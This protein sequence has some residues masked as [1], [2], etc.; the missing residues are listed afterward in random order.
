ML[1]IY[2]ISPKGFGCGIIAFNGQLLTFIQH[3]AQYAKQYQLCKTEFLTSFHC[4]GTGGLSCHCS[5]TNVGMDK[6]R[7]IITFHPSCHCPVAIWCNNIPVATNGT[8]QAT[9]Y[10]NIW[11]LSVK[12]HIMAISILKHTV[13]TMCCD[14]QTVTI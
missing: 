6:Q 13:C 5:P 10:S 9:G 3:C 2:N 12:S 1:D 8:L 7:K 4:S 11:L 14:I